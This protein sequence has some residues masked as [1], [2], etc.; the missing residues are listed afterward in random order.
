MSEHT[1]QENS[2]PQPAWLEQWFTEEADASHKPRRSRAV[3]A[4]LIL[5]GVLL[6]MVLLSDISQTPAGVCG[7]CHTMLPYYHTWQASSHSRHSCVACHA[8]PGFDGT[9]KLAAD[10]ARFAYVQAT[11]TYILPLRLLTGIGDAACLRCHTFNRGTTAAGDLI[12][13][14]ADHSKGQVRCISCHAGAAHGNIGRRRATVS[15]PSASWN[16]L[17]GRRQMSRVF[18][19]APKEDCMVCHFNRRVD[20]TC[21][22]CHQEDKTPADHL[23]GDFLLTHGALARETGDCHRC[24]AYDAHGRKISVYPGENLT[25]YTRRNDFCLDCHRQRPASHQPDFRNH[26]PAAADN[27]AGCMICHDNQPQAALPEASAVYCGSCH[28]SPHRA[29]WQELHN[30][31]RRGARIFPGQKLSAACF[32]CHQRDA[33]LSCHVPPPEEI[34]PPEP[35]PFRPALPQG[36]LPA[37]GSY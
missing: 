13:P 35:E 11:G 3:L 31:R 1:P 29:G 33:C 12:I 6:I 24:H 32:A 21:R 25:A 16:L 22:D 4:P 7:A 17:E 36:Q 26:G 14:H 28:P 8:A 5:L 27:V 23:A 30:R 20:L 15:L 37:P 10:L 2:T 18:T 34:L 9:L 19:A